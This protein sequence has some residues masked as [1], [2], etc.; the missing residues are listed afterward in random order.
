MTLHHT[1]SLP[2]TLSRRNWNMVQSQIMD[3]SGKVFPIEITYEYHVKG[4]FELTTIISNVDYK[5]CPDAVIEKANLDDQI[6]DIIR[7]EERTAI[8][9]F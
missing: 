2:K 9:F 5:L 1:P 4:L 7:L 6:H 3:D 8:E